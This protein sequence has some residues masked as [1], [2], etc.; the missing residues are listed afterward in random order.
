[1]T[2][3]APRPPVG[4][5]PLT[6]HIVITTPAA[7]TTFNGGSNPDTI[8]VQGTVLL[9]CD[10]PGGDCDVGR[11][12]GVTVKLGDSAARPATFTPDPTPAPGTEQSGSWQFSG[13][14]GSSEQG[15][16]TIAAT[17]AMLEG[18]RRTI[19]TG[20]TSITVSIKNGA[21]PVTCADLTEQLMHLT[22]LLA[23][24][25]DPETETLIKERIKAV[26]KE[27]QQQGCT[28]VPL[29]STLT[30]K[31]LIETDRAGVGPFN[32]DVSLALVFSGN[33]V[34]VGFIDLTL[35]GGAHVTSNGGLG[36]FDPS[37]GLMQVDLPIQAHI[38]AGPNVPIDTD[39]N[40]DFTMS[41]ES[42][43]AHG[44]FNPRGVRLGSDGSVTL[45]GAAFD[46]VLTVGVNV[47]LVVSGTVSAHP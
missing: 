40:L 31:A 36:A 42:G 12:S 16:M 35:S 11:I 6:P 38:P 30:G 19:A 27:L 46:S 8:Q 18:A 9:T 20:S 15:N 33:E 23:H 7:G 45:A 1:M 29:Q 24:A 21:R 4:L 37:S 28:P 3:P 44:P 47:L 32:Q 14:P 2:A 22:S 39:L 13:V 26:T 34:S 43:P 10:D 5:T 17:V 41:T 25:T